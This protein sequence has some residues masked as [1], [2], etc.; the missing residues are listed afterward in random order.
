MNFQVHRPQGYIGTG[1]KSLPKIIRDL[2]QNLIKAQDFFA[3]ETLCLTNSKLEELACVLVEFIEDIH[4]DIGIWKCY[5]RYNFEFFKTP[6]PLTLQ[7]NTEIEEK[8]Q[9]KYRVQQLLYV[10]YPELIPGLILSPSHKDLIFL[11]DYIFKFLEQQFSQVPQGSGIKTFLSQTN[12]YGWDVKRKLIWLG[13]HSYF[14]RHSFQNYV[15][16]EHGGKMEIPIIDDFICQ[17]NTCWSGLGIIDI[18]AAVLDINE[19]RRQ[20]LRSWYER[21][22]GY[23]KVIA[24]K[25]PIIEM[26]NIINDQPYKVR[27]GWDNSSRFKV[28][29]IVFGSLVP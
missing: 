11:A 13:Q 23:Y 21:H 7:P 8:E 24:V 2:E 19:S 20:E 12:K 10:L 27:V 6:L 26:I 16:K 25:G 9:L 5:E 14:F 4:N 18:L 3:Y 17:E 28:Q 29:Q 15:I 1:D 22:I